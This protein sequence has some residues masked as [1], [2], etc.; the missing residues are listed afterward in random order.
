GGHSLLAT[1]VMSRLR[2]VFDVEM[3]LRT[4]F[5]Q[6]TVRGLAQAIADGQSTGTSLVKPPIRPI[7]RSGY[8]PLSFAQQRLWFLDQLEPGNPFYNMSAGLRLTGRLDTSALQSALDDIVRRHE[9]LRTTFPAVDGQPVQRITPPGPLALTRT[10]LRHLPEAQRL[11]EAQR[12]ADLAAQTPFDLTTDALLR[13]ALI[14]VGDE[15]HI[16]VVTLHHIVGD[17]WS[18]GILVNEFSTL[19][20]AAANGQPSPLPDLPIQYGDFAV[21]QRQWLQS[22]RIDAQLGY[23]KQQLQG[24]H[25]H[26][27]LPGDRPRPDVL[28]FQGATLTFD[29]PASVTEPL[30]ALSR[31]EGITLYMALLAAFEVLLHSYSG[32]EDFIVGSP[33]ANRTQEDTESLIGF[34]ANT[35]P[36]RADVS[37]SP[38]MRQLMQRVRT[39]ALGGFAHQDV[40]FETIVQAISPTRSLAY[41][42]LFQVLFILQNAPLKPVAL[43]G[44]TLSPADSRNDT[45]KFDLTLS[46]SETNNGLQGSLEY[47][48]DLFDTATAAAL[49][50]DFASVLDACVTA[51]DQPIDRILPDRL[52]Q[53]KS[54]RKTWDVVV[55]ATF[56]AEPIGDSLTYC[57]DDVHVPHRLAF[58]PYGQLIQQLLDP[59]GLFAHN[60]GGL[61]LG[62]LRWEDWLRHESQD[63]GPEALAAKLAGHL[64]LFIAAVR[65]AAASQRAALLLVICP[66]SD[67]FLVEPVLRVC[68]SDLEH[69]LITAVAA[70]PG[71][72]IIG[73][74]EVAGAY[75]NADGRDPRRDELAHVPY[76]PA[77]FTALGAMAASCIA[78]APAVDPGHRQTL[79]LADA[80]VIPQAAADALTVTS[81]M[82]Q[83]NLAVT[84]AAPQPGQMAKT[85]D[86]TQ[87][88][89]QLCTTGIG[90][91]AEA[92]DALGDQ[93]MVC[94]AVTVRDR[95][96]D[97]GV[98]GTLLYRPEAESLMVDTLVLSCLAFG[99]GVEHR[100]LATAGKTALAVGLATVAVP[101]VVSPHNSQT[102]AF[103]D[104]VAGPFRETRPDGFLYRLPSQLAA[105]LCLDDE[106]PSSAV[107]FPSLTA[108]TRPTLHPAARQRLVAD[109]G[110]PK[111]L[112]ERIKQHKRRVRSE[113][114]GDYVAA[115]TATEQAVAAIW[116]D[117]LGV[118]RI[119]ILDNFFELGG[120][121]LLATQVISRLR[122]A[123]DVDLPLRALFEH[124]TVQ[125]LAEAIAEHQAVAPGFTKPALLPTVRHGDQAVSFAQQRLWF[126]DQLEPG[127]AAYNMPAALRLTGTLQLPVLATVLTE[128]VRRHESLRTT[129][130]T[131]DGK[132]WQ[133]IADAGPMPLPVIDLTDRTGDVQAQALR[134][135]IDAEANKPFD[136]AAGPLFRATL[137]RLG[138]ESHVL[139][140]TMH[141]IVSDGWSI[142]VLV[143]ETAALY[144]AYAA[145][146]A[147]PLPELAIQYADYAV[148]QRSW[149]QGEPLSDLVTYWKGKLSGDLVPLPL[150]TDRPRPA[151]QSFAGSVRRLTLPPALGHSLSTLGQRHGATLYM[152]LLAAYQTLLYRLSNQSDIIVASPIAGRTQTALENQVGFFVNTLA[153]RTDVAAGTAFTALLDQVKQ[154]SLEAFA[155]QDLPF[156]MLVQE[157]QPE[158]SLSHPPIAQAMFTLQESAERRLQLGDLQLDV[159]PAAQRTAKFDLTL[160]VITGEAGLE[161]EWEYNTDLFDGE[162]VDRWMGHFQTLLAAIVAAPETAVDRLDILTAT[163]VTH[164]LVDWNRTGSVPATGL[165]MHQLFEQQVART[166]D[167][168]ALVHPDRSLSYR[169]LDGRANQLAHRLQ[170]LGVGPE[171][172]VGVCL[173]RNIDLVVGLLGILKAGG[174]YVPL[175]P[176]YPAERLAFILEDTA[177]PVLLTHTS[178]SGLVPAGNA[179]VLHLD[180]D[181]PSIATESASAPSSPVTDRN[182]GYIIYTSGSTGRPKG[183]AIE[184]RN[185][186]T[187][188]LWA[189][190]VYPPAVLKGVLAATSICFDLSVY[191]LFLPISVG[192]TIF[193]ADNALHLPTLPARDRIT[194]VNTVPS[195]MSELV[196]SGGLPASV[197][198][199]NLAG[200]PLPNELAQ[201]VYRTGVTQVWNLY[202]PSEDTT[203]STFTLVPNGSTV[204]VHIGRPIA[205]TQAYVLDGNQQ[206]V[207]IG[208]IGELYLGGDGLSRGYLHRPELTAE[209]YV[210]NPFGPGRLYKTG[211][212]VRYLPD[213]NLDYVGRVDFQ[214]KVRGF[215]IELGEI[216]SALLSQPGVREAIV[217][218]REDQPGDKRIVAYLT[219]GSAAGID[220]VALKTALKTRL[221]DYMVPSAFVVMDQLPLTPNGKI[222]RKALPAPEWRGTQ[223]EKVLPRNVVEQ[224]LADIWAEILDIRDIGVFDNFFEL[225]GHSLLATRLVSRVRDT[226]SID[227]PLRRLF[228]SP[229]IATMAETILS[230]NAELFDE[231]L[232]DLGDDDA[233]DTP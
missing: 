227:L 188:L 206:P 55:A 28:T 65:T 95:F 158:R 57:L 177:A 98:V 194:L 23:W 19:Y 6:P 231:L 92:I 67:R 151:Q 118:E 47:S 195:A 66:P 99:R 152:V 149:L 29:I 210:P 189:Q 96:G 46:L 221:P 192:G 141:H 18:V 216:E 183:V 107:P 212:L 56:T 196:R 147:S 220:P 213:S 50:G 127:S 9:S 155:H 42:P 161:T 112:L 211:D 140:V 52:Q 32:Q 61:N 171:T 179:Q 30:K 71:V 17:G 222:E 101:V 164:L 144:A 120:H 167:A 89:N 169:E 174:A 138:A 8:L 25:T 178:L 143:D 190:K 5:E 131:V 15:E 146:A 62:L 223:T 49:A 166:P 78:T 38:S 197:R 148:W 102:V 20:D 232:S 88:A 53:A 54:R 2:Q 109:W 36:L 72:R 68:L 91:T 40:P 173:D 193:L 123:C 74:D 93:G 154:T 22:E 185:A 60:A 87:H 132:P 113:A 215:R 116:A 163:E 126:L 35:L 207:P 64:G 10:D 103:L 26:L 63:L 170:A 219:A 41:S 204:P 97:Y 198:V 31:S 187:M 137:V 114:A 7:D 209:K 48:T 75:P 37:G 83:L 130:V 34:F 136:L 145:G 51:L 58:A 156:E 182:L 208:V 76:M 224:L 84:I 226:L 122:Q 202:G 168:V 225:G 70:L 157:V 11:V 27:D 79:R 180:T 133:R 124:P 214:V 159:V 59:Q 134:Q 115:T 14:Q 175:D 139:L 162:T 104:A 229:T 233:G 86:L 200:E 181:W 1:R 121:S 90:R 184:H 24:V 205:D 110:N 80:Q 105:N 199:V 13:G 45:A 172:L 16:L 217:Q 119:G 176:A 69:Q 117:V 12:S 128:L 153:M 203:Y 73:S 135:A 100:M 150:P 77:F 33:I 218:V 111:S 21:W 44:L 39:V 85:A 160:S 129:I 108:V 186:V 94:H 3:P 82:A 230:E 191:E 81:F 43:S 142:G 4:L 228:E 165:G 201:R 106:T 125:R